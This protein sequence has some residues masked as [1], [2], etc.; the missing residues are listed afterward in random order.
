MDRRQAIKLAI[1]GGVALGALGGLGLWGRY[2]L[3]P[4]SRSTRLESVEAL[5]VR[6]YDSLDA[7]TRDRACVGYDHPL[8]QYH[9]RGVSCGGVDISGL[10]PQ[11]L[12]LGSI[13]SSDLEPVFEEIGSPVLCLQNALLFSPTRDRFVIAAEQDLRHLQAPIFSRSGVLAAL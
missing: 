8:R 2:T 3:L 12:R 13:A 9:N 1:R 6:L 4:P 10:R 7:T 11:I 5:A